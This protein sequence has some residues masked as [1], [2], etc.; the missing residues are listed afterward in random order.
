MQVMQIVTNRLPYQVFKNTKY[1]QLPVI[2]RLKFMFCL[3]W[4]PDVQVDCCTLATSHFALFLQLFGKRLLCSR[5]P[6]GNSIPKKQTTFK[7]EFVKIE[8]MIFWETHHLHQE[9]A[10]PR[11]C[12]LKLVE[13]VTV[14]D[15]DSGKR[16]DDSLVQI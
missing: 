6:P 5:K 11:R 12:Q 13:V 8:M 4:N 3:F 14:A 15:A 10:L 16:V 9:T 2:L 7:S 1:D